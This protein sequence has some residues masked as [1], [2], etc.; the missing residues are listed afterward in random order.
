MPS[1]ETRKILCEVIEN[2]SLTYTE[3]RGL[4]CFF[5][6][7]SVNYNMHGPDTVNHEPNCVY[8]RIQKTLNPE[9]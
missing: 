9:P 4:E 8:V 1:E 6:C 2:G 7:G 5:C 3:D